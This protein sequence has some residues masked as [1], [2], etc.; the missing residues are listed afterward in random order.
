MSLLDSF[1][2]EV[3]AAPSFEA[4]AKDVK[5][6]S[7]QQSFSTYAGFS[8]TSWPSSDTYE[9]SSPSAFATDF[10]TSC[11]DVSFETVDSCSVNWTIRSAESI[12]HINHLENRLAKLQNDH[13]DRRKVQKRNEF[14]I[15]LPEGFQLSTLVSAHPEDDNQESEALLVGARSDERPF[16]HLVEHV[17][18]VVHNVTLTLR[19]LCSATASCFTP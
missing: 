1:L 16:S 10:V 6:H 17:Q 9:S 15:Q 3:S 13:T 5:D 19:Q 14:E 11:E 8:S 7:G 2:K 12:K 18:R 4:D